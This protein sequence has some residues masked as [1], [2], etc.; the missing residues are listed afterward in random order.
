MHAAS[1][2][3][4][5]TKTE[6]LNKM[7][8]RLTHSGDIVVTR[9]TQFVYNTVENLFKMASK[10]SNHKYIQSCQIAS[11]GLEGHCPFFS[12]ATKSVTAIVD[13]F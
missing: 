4:F 7:K 10:T 3:L 5:T 8:V 13:D 2:S 11:F 6:V 1:I 9:D 12:N